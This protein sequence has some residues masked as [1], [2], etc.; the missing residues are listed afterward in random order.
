MFFFAGPEKAGFTSPYGGIENGVVSV[1]LALLISSV[2]LLIEKVSFLILNTYIWDYFDI[3]STCRII[4]I[5]IV[6]I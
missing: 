1:F 6:I 3:L 2:V 5:V 4:I